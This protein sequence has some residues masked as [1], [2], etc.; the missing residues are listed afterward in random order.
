VRDV[1]IIRQG[2]C[3]KS[4]GAHGFSVGLTKNNMAP[5]T[6]CPNVIIRRTE[7]GLKEGRL[8]VTITLDGLTLIGLRLAKGNPKIYPH[9]QT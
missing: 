2:I 4:L 7:Q 1:D 8:R 5:Q 3:C 6:L 9:G